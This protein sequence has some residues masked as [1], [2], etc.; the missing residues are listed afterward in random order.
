MKTIEIAKIS[1]PPRQREA[2]APQH[3]RDLKAAILS[4]GFTSPILLSQEGENF[5]LIAGH[6]RLTAVKEL[7]ED[8]HGF[9]CDKDPTPAGCIPFVLISDLSPADLAE[10]ELQE[11]VLRAQLTWQEET[12]ARLM[13]HQLRTLQNPGQSQSATGRELA[14]R[15]GN[16]PGQEQV[17]LHRATTIAPYLQNPRVKN[18][19]SLSEAYR[20]VQ[21]M[22]SASLRRDLV[23]RGMVQ[24]PHDVRLGDCRSI[25]PILTGGSFDTILCDPPYGIKADE[26]KKTAGHHYDDDPAYG[27]EISKLIIKEGFR[28]LKDRGIF[29]MFC[30][31]EH[32]LEL[33]EHG[34]NQ[35]YTAWRTPLVW[36]KGNEGFAPW[37]KDGFARTYELLLFL[38]KGA[39]GLK[40][41]GPDVKSFARPSRSER[42]HAAEKP[43]AL[44]SYLLSLTGDSGDLVLDPCCGSGP[45]LEAA[46]ERQMRA[47]AIE[48]DP[49]YHAEAVARLTKE[50][51]NA[52]HESLIPDDAKLLQ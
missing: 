37:G 38:T 31:V 21:D 39:K 47:V 1:I 25:L 29:M 7:W 33:R 48:L 8:G 12:Q 40:G 6:G 44:L 42:S 10:A 18:A 20:N 35:G 23:A 13:I 34:K 41:G 45:T 16:S 5:S 26:M 46:T 50:A 52:N 4:K 43:V 30:D 14:E 32:F 3:I 36:Q 49:D 2:H 22:H 51:E 11:N 24:S 17:T 28:L 9:T 15:S 19:K 27:L